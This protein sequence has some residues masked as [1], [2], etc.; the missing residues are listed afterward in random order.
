MDAPPYDIAI[1]G[2]GPVGTTLALLL[3]ARH[4]DAARII[5]IDRQTEAAAR[6]DPRVIALSAGS[7]QILE[8]VAPVA[9]LDAAPIR[10]IHVSQAGH[11]GH[12][13]LD[14]REEGVAAL[15]AVVRYGELMRVLTAA[16]AASGVRVR[17]PAAAHDW[18]ENAQAAR[19]TDDTGEHDAALLVRAEGGLFSRVRNSAADRAGLHRDY[20][21]S[22]VIAEVICARP[23]PG[24][25]YER[26][27]RHGP[28]AMLPLPEAGRYALVWC[29]RPDIAAEIVA[30]DDAVFLARLQASFGDRLGRLTG[31]SVRHAYPLGLVRQRDE[32]A[33]RCV[34]IG[35]AAQTLHPVAGQGLNLGLRDAF[36]LAE[37]CAEY[38]WTPQA[39][40]AMRRRRAADR[41][42]TIALTDAF[43]RGFA[44]PFAPLRHL[45]GLGLAAV[46][47]SSP[48]RSL[49]A[50][51]MRFGLRA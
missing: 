10:R 5:V 35:N 30:L 31:V 18:S 50:R 12:A 44:L 38:G 7:L 20:G 6:S 15:G 25:A 33:R 19:W 13:L 26:F 9:E 1:F 11:F 8:R 4:A 24:T 47:L 40:A 39:V 32:A 37:A 41:A 2:G 23:R 27:T 49:L 21:Q 45:A 16:L 46:D 51:Q 28:L 34:R 3:A 14:A 48:L 29:E 36:G 43:A 22:A 42:T 17:R